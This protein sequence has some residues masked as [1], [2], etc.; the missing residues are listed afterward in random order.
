VSG[1][2]GAVR[3][4]NQ[5]RKIARITGAIFILFVMTIRKKETAFL[6]YLPLTGDPIFHLPRIY[7]YE[8]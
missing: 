8:I 4:K 3:Y 2:L 5:A 6:S 1:K 7:L